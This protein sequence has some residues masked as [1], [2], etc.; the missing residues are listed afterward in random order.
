[1]NE[2]NRATCRM[3][4]CPRC[5]QPAGRTCVTSSGRPAQYPHAL[6]EMLARRIHPDPWDQ[7]TVELAFLDAVTVP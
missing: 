7:L 6:R 1:M 3:V 4:A 5:A 2:H